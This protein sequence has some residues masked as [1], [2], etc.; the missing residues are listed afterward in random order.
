MATKTLL[1]IEV[2]NRTSYAPDREFIDGELRERNVGTFEHARIQLL[3]GTLFQVH[4]REWNIQP[5]TEC[6]M[7]VNEQRTRIPDLAVLSRGPHPSVLTDPPLI[8]VEV[9]SPDDTYGDMRERALDYS[10]MGIAHIW[11]VDPL[12]RT[13]QV[14]HENRWND[15]TEFAVPSTSVR[16]TLASLFAEFDEY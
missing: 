8:V 15:V 14:F 10:R 1:P 4:S 16:I 13:G 12:T 9:L 5:V 3:L 11:L 7:R 2:Y 6:R